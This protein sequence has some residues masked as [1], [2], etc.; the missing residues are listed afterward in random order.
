[1]VVITKPLTIAHAR[2]LVR[3]D[4]IEQHFTDDPLVS[5][6]RNKRIVQVRWSE[7]TPA[8]KRAAECQMNNP[9]GLF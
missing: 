4:D 7:L 5:T 9:C 3:E 1:M 8:E 2:N 6:I